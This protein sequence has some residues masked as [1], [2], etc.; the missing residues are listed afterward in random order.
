VHLSSGIV[1]A[2]EPVKL[3]TTRNCLTINEPGEMLL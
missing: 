2:N 1:S 3:F